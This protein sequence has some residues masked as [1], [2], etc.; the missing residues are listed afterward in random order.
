MGGGAYS[1]ELLQL[2]S[3]LRM[4]AKSAEGNVEARP[5]SSGRFAVATTAGDDLITV[6]G[7][8][9]DTGIIGNVNVGGSDVSGARTVA[10]A[11]GSGDATIELAS[12]GDGE[13]AGL[14]LTSPSGS[15]ESA[16]YRMAKTACPNRDGLPRPSCSSLRI[17]A[18]DAAANGEIRMVASEIH[19]DDGHF[20]ANHITVRSSTATGFQG[21]TINLNSGIITSG[22]SVLEPSPGLTAPN[23]PIP[24][25]TI[26]FNN[27]RVTP[28]SVILASVVDQC[29]D[30]TGITITEISPGTGSLVFTVANFGTRACGGGS[31]SADERYTISWYMVSDTA[32]VF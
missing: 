16:Q 6:H 11:T 30:R 9:G 4:D 29:N 22:A 26:S 28:T 32:Q 20:L 24:T 3:S 2:G 7:T 5:G 18:G 17:D 27:F 10:V 12:G 15:G 14:Y 25:E 13:T 19:T 23:D 8:S 21:Q 1:F 31:L